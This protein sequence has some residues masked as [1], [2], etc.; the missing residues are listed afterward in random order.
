MMMLLIFIQSLAFGVEEA[1]PSVY[2]ENRRGASQILKNEPAA[3]IEN[4]S[5]G[6]ADLPS[7]ATLHL[8]IG[9]AFEQTGQIDKAMQ[10]YQNAEKISNDPAIKFQ[11]IFNQAQIQ[12]KD[13][14]IDEAL[15]LYQKA[16][17]IDP[18]SVPVKTNIELLLQG[19]GQG[20]GK[21]DNDKKDDKDKK[22]QQGKGD[23]KDDKGKDQDDKPKDDKDGDKQ[24]KKYAPQQRKQ[25]KP[26]KSEELTE[27]DVK[28]IFGEIKQ[29]EQ[30]IRGEFGKKTIKE[31]PQG[32][33]W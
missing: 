28:K 2:F 6:L 13:K 17:E 26:F 15:T 1:P 16:L 24:D 7:S 25:P 3:S 27:S 18:D 19:Q 12:G 14:K 4:F 23:P 22:D 20:G 5:N 9:L 33:D 32:K 11:A 8:N 29:Q 30:K 10:S 31:K 21:D